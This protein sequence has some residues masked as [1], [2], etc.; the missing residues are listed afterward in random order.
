MANDQIQ[1]SI[2]KL[3]DEEGDGWTLT[4][5]VVCMGLARMTNDG[6][7]SVAWYYAPDEQPDWQTKGLLE[8]AT[9]LHDNADDED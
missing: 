5:Y 1:Q 6:V 9:I 2:Q 4:Q 7:E 8:Q 3:L